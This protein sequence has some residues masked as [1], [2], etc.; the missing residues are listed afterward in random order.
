MKRQNTFLLFIIFIF[1]QLPFTYGMVN[2][3]FGLGPL[4]DAISLVI[5]NFGAFF[6]FMGTFIYT[7]KSSKEFFIYK[8]IWL[9]EIFI[10]MGLFGTILGFALTLISLNTSFP[11]GVDPSAATISNMAIS[12]ITLIYGFLSAATVYLIQKFYELKRNKIEGVEIK[13]PKEGFLISSFIYFLLFIIFEFLSLSIGGADIGGFVYIISFESLI[14]VITLFLIFFLFYNGDS[15]IN[16]IKNIWWYVPDKEKNIL[17]NLNF[18]RNMKKIAAI[19]V[20]VSLLCA[21]IIMLAAL[22]W[23]SEENNSLGWNSFTFSGLENGSIIFFW[24]LNFIILLTI[25]EG[26]EA[27]KLY[28]ITGKISAGDR[29][30]SI[31]YILAPA[32]LLFFTFSFGILQTFL[33]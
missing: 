12:L 21:P 32:F 10:I 25:I 13:T 4:W 22:A 28:F 33:L 16:L 7:V 17:Y 29:F 26:R 15:P 20:G 24:V 3:S 6:L 1:I 14:C 19:M 30:Y 18:V 8:L 11:P 5:V 31:K 2:D 23:P 27:S 9:Q